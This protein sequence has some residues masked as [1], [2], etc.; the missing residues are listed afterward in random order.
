MVLYMYL[1]LAVIAPNKCQY[2]V[3]ITIRCLTPINVIPWEGVGG[4]A[5]GEWKGGLDVND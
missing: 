4:F 1:L 3:D 5:L 2:A